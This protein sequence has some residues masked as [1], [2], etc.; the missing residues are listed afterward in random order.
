MG[1]RSIVNGLNT[2]GRSIYHQL[3]GFQRQE[4]LSWLRSWGIDKDRLEFTHPI[5]VVLGVEEIVTRALQVPIAVVSATSLSRKVIRY[6][7]NS[8]R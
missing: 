4:S 1:A 2:G 5:S 3:N 8:P 6:V 7:D